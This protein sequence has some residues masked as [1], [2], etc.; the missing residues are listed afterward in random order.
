MLVISIADSIKSVV[1]VLFL[2]FMIMYCIGVY[3]TQVVTVHKV[4]QSRKGI[5][6]QSALESNYGTLLKTMLS[7]FESIAS[8]VSWREVMDPLWEHC[9][10]WM[11][12]FFLAY[13]FFTIFVVLNVVTGVFVG[14]ATEKANED[15]KKVL[16]F[17]LRELFRAAD[18][19]ND[20]TMT[21]TK[22]QGKLQDTKMQGYLKAIDLDQ[23]EALDLFHLLDSD[24]SDEIDED[25]F[26]NG[27]IRL[28]GYAKSI[29][30]ATFMFDYKNYTKMWSE[31]AWRIEHSLEEIMDRLLVLQEAAG[32]YDV[33]V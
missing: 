2:L 16:M 25:E 31:H 21:W 3:F 23:E 24:D 5:Q 14:S 28:H 19:D 9:S 8:G 33:A 12:V 7:L 29:D 10:P 26:V 11:L 27:C 32:R 30:L 15:Q 20:G 4:G 17:Q 22:F 13:V 6:V 18:V 1:W